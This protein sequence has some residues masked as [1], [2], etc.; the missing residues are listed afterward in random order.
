MNRKILS[1]HQ[2]TLIVKAGA[3]SIKND[4]DKKGQL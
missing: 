1:V 4:N 2:V 3:V